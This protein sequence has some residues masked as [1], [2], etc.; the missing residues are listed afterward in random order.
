MFKDQGCAERGCSDVVTDSTNCFLQTGGRWLLDLLIPE[1][2]HLCAI[3]DSTLS[4]HSDIKSITKS[5]FVHLKNISRLR[6]SLSDSVAE[7]LIHAFFTSRLD[8]CDGV[9]SGAP[10][11]ALD[12][13]QYVHNSA[14]R[15]PPAPGPGTHQPTLHW[16]PIKSH[17]D[18][19]TLLLVY[20]N[21]SMPCTTLPTLTRPT[22][23]YYYYS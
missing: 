4:L 22:F 2:R 3:L 8:C 15:L 14:A 6:P 12:R 18:Y 23:Y 21:L 17:I 1:V 11:K 5:A 9:L 16:L 20:T 10:S 7:T 19:K 13:L